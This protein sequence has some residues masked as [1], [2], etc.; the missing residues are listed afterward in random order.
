MQQTWMF[1][2]PKLNCLH[3]PKAPAN[4]NTTAFSFPCPVCLEG[5]CTLCSL[6]TPG[7]ESLQRSQVHTSPVRSLTREQP[8]VLPPHWASWVF[9]MRHHGLAGSDQMEKHPEGHTYLRESHTRRV[10]WKACLLTLPQQLYKPGGDSQLN[11][12][13][14]L[15]D[16][17]SWALNNPV[18]KSVTF[19]K[20]MAQFPTSTQYPEGPFDNHT[21]TSEMFG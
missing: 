21:N 5:W 3:L 15:A 11:M 17:Q 9:W 13:H 8:N 14:C 12:F 1:L 10:E 16:L 7:A 6:L 20:R 2:L 19:W 4:T 18:L